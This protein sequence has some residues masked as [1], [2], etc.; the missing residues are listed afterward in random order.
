MA[1]S[2]YQTL[3][4][5][6]LVNRRVMLRILLA[7]CSA[8]AFRFS[9]AVPGS[10]LFC[11]RSARSSRANTKPRTSKP[12]A[13]STDLPFNVPGAIPRDSTESGTVIP[14]DFRIWRAISVDEPAM[15]THW[16]PAA[17]SEMLT[18]RWTVTPAAVSDC[19]SS[20][21]AHCTG[22]E[23][24]IGSALVRI[25]TPRPT[26]RAATAAREV[27]PVTRKN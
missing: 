9:R 10:G 11:T 24:A 25:D 15:R 4:S 14:A 18:Q 3:S 2:L 27:V 13:S 23:R 26:P 19:S 1:W 22:P 12:V 7:G 17:T 21:A 16:F 6:S 5:T 20:L 8:D